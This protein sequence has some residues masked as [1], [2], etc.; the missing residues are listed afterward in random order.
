[1]VSVGLRTAPRGAARLA[2]A[3]AEPVRAVRREAGCELYA[4][5]LVSD[6]ELLLWERWSSPAAYDAHRDGVAIQ[7]VLQTARAF[8]SRPM[9][10]TRATPIGEVA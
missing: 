2:D 4:L 3:L 1:M 7:A 8:L 10:V 6:Q 9:T 5:H